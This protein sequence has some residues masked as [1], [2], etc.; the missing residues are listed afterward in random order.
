MAR[1]NDQNIIVHARIMSLVHESESFV[2]IEC[3]KFIL[4]KKF[5]NPCLIFTLLFA[6]HMWLTLLNGFNVEVKYSLNCDCLVIS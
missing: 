4:S 3:V 6:A 1:I 5:E 2:L